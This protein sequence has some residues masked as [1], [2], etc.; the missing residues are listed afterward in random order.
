MRKFSKHQHESRPVPQTGVPDFPGVSNGNQGYGN[1][2]CTGRDLAYILAR[3]KLSD[4]ESSAWQADLK[5]ARKSLSP[6]P[7]RWE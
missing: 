4:Q 3:L 2:V 5:I 6:Q 1:K 7:V